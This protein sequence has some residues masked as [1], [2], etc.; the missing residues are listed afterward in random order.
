M[1]K[2]IVASNNSKKIK[3]IKEILSKYPVEVVSLK[4]AGIDVE[5]EEDG[6]TFVENAYKK[7]IEI[8]KIIPECMVLADD[9]GLMVDCLGGAPGVYSARFAGEHGNDKKNNE[10]LLSLLENKEEHEKTA[11]FV[12]AIVLVSDYD[13]LIKV[14]GELEGVILDRERGENGFGYDPIFY[15]PKYEMTCAEMNSDL[16]NVI[17]HRAKAFEKLEEQIKKHIMEG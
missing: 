4:E 3:E 9:S 12:C 16:K 7:A 2:L 1:R 15:V 17:S 13:N 11:K 8:Y 5:V 6:N 14:E 10:K